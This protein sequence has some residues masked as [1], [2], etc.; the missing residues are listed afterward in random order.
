M[1]Q[2]SLGQVV[3]G[4]LSGINVVV[5]YIAIRRLSRL[6]LMVETMWSAFLSGQFV[7]R[8]HGVAHNHGSEHGEAVT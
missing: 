3:Q 2:V 8:R 5:L 6:E 7:E 4:V 1:I